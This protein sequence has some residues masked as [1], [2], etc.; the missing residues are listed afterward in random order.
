MKKLVFRPVRPVAPVMP[1]VPIAPMALLVLLALLWSGGAACGAGGSFFIKNGDRVCFYGASITEQRFHAVDVETYVL[2]RFPKLHVRFVNSGVGGDGVA[3]GWAGPIKLRLRR[4]VFAFKPD[5]VIINDLPMN[6]TRYRPF[7]PKTYRAFCKGYVHIIRSL[8]AHLPGVRIVLVEPAAFDD[9]TH[10]PRFPGGVN[11]VLLKYCGF[12]RKVAAKDHLLCVNMNR[13]MV[14]V[15]K[16]A[17][18]ADPVLAKQIIPGR[19]HPSAAGQ[20]VMAQALLKAMGARAVVTAVTINA[21]K[22]SVSAAAHTAVSGLADNRGV[23]SWRQADRC[24]PM[25]VMSLHENWP[26]FPPIG[27]WPAPAPDMARTNPVTAFTIKLSGFMHALDREPLRVTH[28][29][30]AEYALR[31][32]GKL[33]GTFSAAELAHGINLARLPTPML[34]Q[35]Y[36]VMALAWERTQ[37]RFTYWRQVQLPMADIGQPGLFPLNT[38]SSVKARRAVGAIGRAFNQLQ[39]LII[40]RQRMA[41]QP[42]THR[43][44]LVPEN[45]AA[46]TQAQKPRGGN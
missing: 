37:V 4:D 26:Q 7:N 27:L 45:G 20:L 35:A 42:T 32:D 41:A 29:T 33:M 5:V 40:R 36:K 38:N 2:T 46:V 24:L 19:L 17:E 18:R 28:L 9:I 16:A 12:I 13:P 22:R 11:G 21:K 23:L 30:A 14:E 34:A 43:F 6:D 3:G 10:A 8:R 25:P 15:L 39:A 44:Q 1:I 31:I